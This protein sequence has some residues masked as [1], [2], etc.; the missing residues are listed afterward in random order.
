MSGIFGHEI[1][2]QNG[3]NAALH[4]PDRTHRC[5]PFRDEAPEVQRIIVRG[6]NFWQKASGMQLREDFCIDFVCFHTRMRNCLHLQRVG[7]DHAVHKGCQQPDNRRRVPGCFQNHFILRLQ[8]LTEG[9]HSVMLQ[10]DPEVL[11]DLPVFKD[12]DLC[13]TSVHVHSN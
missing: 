11:D 12:R 6:P 5:I 8:A 4:T 2:M 7:D 10:V 9:Q 3:L 13:K 1:G